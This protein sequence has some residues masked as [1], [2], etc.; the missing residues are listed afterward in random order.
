MNE[1]EAVTM[2]IELEIPAS[3]EAINDLIDDL[4]GSCSD[5][6]S[7]SVESGLSGESPDVSADQFT[8]VD[9]EGFPLLTVTLRPK[10]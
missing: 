10:S 6:D 8:L 5:D 9:S 2:K 4:E 3:P 1:G 7:L